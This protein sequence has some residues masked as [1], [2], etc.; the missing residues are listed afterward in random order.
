VNG[1]PNVLRS[2]LWNVVSA[3][4]LPLLAG[5]CVAFDLGSPPVAVRALAGGVALALVACAGRVLT[6]GVRA[7]PDGLVVRELFSTKTLPWAAI[8]GAKLVTHRPQT[9]G[10]PS[11]S[12]SM[13]ELRYVDVYGNRRR[14]RITAL[15]A[16]RIAAARRNVDA[17]NE[18]IR[19]RG[20]Q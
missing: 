2:W 13:P 8:R 12:T 5:G 6:V 11:V 7:T 9:F 15:G 20:T 18:L 3:G 16:R 4:V 17:L 14:V 19:T 10:S 1:E